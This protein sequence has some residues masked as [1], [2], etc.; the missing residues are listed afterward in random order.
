MFVASCHSN[1]HKLHATCLQSPL[2]DMSL[3]PLTADYPTSNIALYCHE[4]Q[5]VQSAGIQQQNSS[6]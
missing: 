4:V 5:Y 6:Q 1:D 2:T 3:V